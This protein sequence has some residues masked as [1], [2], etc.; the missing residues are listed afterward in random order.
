M[1]RERERYGKNV[2]TF[3][4]LKKINFAIVFHLDFSSCHPD[5]IIRFDS[6]H[7]EGK[8]AKR[9]QRKERTFNSLGTFSDVTNDFF[10]AELFEFF[11]FQF[12]KS[13]LLHL[14]TVRKHN[15]VDLLSHCSTH[16]RLK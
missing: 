3:K 13:K 2:E 5:Y 11:F 12:R 4:T 9:R 16:I 8:L 7:Y 6:I 1:E 15:C 10:F 14:R